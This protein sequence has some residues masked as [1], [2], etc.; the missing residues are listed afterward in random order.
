MHEHKSS[1]PNRGHCNFVFKNIAFHRP[2]EFGFDDK[3]TTIFQFSRVI[4]KLNGVA[5]TVVEIF[6]DAASRDG[7]HRLPGT[8]PPAG[9]V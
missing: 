7:G 2:G 1:V 4:E 9:S 3:C 8:D 6:P 5:A